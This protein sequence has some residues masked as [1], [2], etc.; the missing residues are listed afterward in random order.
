M[1][2]HIVITDEFHLNIKNPLNFLSF[3]FDVNLLCHH[4]TPLADSEVTVAV[5]PCNSI[6]P[7]RSDSSCVTMQLHWSTAKWHLLC[8]HA[9]PYWPTAKWH[10]LCHHANPLANSEVTIAAS[11]CSWIG[12][13]R[14][15]N[16]CVTMQLNWPT[17]KWQFSSRRYENMKYEKYIAY[18]SISI[19]E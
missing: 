19:L 7:Q 6:G 5:S 12:R 18:Y 16:C 14:S 13:Q 4:K 15:D 2:V 8:H 1:Y 9:T 10:L 17:A 3:S 11:P